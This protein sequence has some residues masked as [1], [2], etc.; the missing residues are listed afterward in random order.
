MSKRKQKRKKPF[1]KKLVRALTEDGRPRLRYNDDSLM[2]GYI[3]AHFSILDYW[4]VYKKL[5][6]GDHSPLRVLPLPE[7]YISFLIEAARLPSK[8][9][10][11]YRNKK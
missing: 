8:Y 9:F 4:R 1:K 7:G 2:L 6:N 5:Y 11:A 10:D 3:K